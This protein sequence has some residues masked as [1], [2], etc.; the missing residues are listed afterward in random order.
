MTAAEK[1]RADR[2]S[3]W[4]LEVVSDYAQAEAD[5][6]AYW[7]AAS[8]AERLNG[9]EMLREQLYGKDQSSCTSSD[10]EGRT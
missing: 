3:Q 5:T 1:R 8:P 10:S 4:K 9:L 7:H 6:R 2:R